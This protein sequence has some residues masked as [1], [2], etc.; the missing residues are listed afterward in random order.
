MRWQRVARIVVAA[1]GISTAAAV[2]LLTR[3]RTPQEPPALV[4][5]ADPAAKMQSGAGKDVR[6]RGDELLGTVTY[7]SI[8]SYENNRV[9][10][11]AFE[12]QLPDG[13]RLSA[14]RVETRGNSMGGGKPDEMSLK[15][16][17][18]LETKD[19]TELR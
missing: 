7:T 9:V 19:G 3:E 12:Y 13:T 10:W 6:Y 11:E 17:V 15:G 5:E 16:R 4:S 14:D 2:Y 1:V 18:R 8:R